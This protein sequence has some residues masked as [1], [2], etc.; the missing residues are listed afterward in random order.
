MKKIYIFLS[1]VLFSFAASAQCS[2]LYFSEYVE[3]SSNNKALE[4]YNASGSTIDLS[5]YAVIR[6]NNGGVT[7]PDTFNMN[8]MLASEGVYI[9]ANPSANAAILAL[10]DT[11]GSATF[12][13]GDDALA[14]TN[15]S[16]STIIDLF[17][18][19]GVDPGSAW[20]WVSGATNNSTLV[21]NFNVQSGVTAWDTLEWVSSVND[22][23]SNLG[24]HSSS[25]YPPTATEPTT[26]AA[27]P[28]A[29]QVDVISLFSN[30]YTNVTVDTWRTPWS[31]ATL[32]D[33][34]A[35]GNDIKRYT[36][37]DFVGIEAVGVNS[38]DASGMDYFTF[39][40]WTPN[41]TTYRIKVVDFGSDNAFGGGDDTEHQIEFASPAQAAWTNHKINM[42]DFTGL[43]NSANVSQFIFSALPTGGATLF[44]DNVYF[45][46][47]PTLVYNVS[48][49]A[50]VVALDA[51]FS[52]VN[53]DTLYEVTGIVYGID[54][55]GGATR[56]QFTLIDATD[57][58]GVF[59]E[60][61]LDYVVNEGD[62][63]TVKGPLGFFRG[64]TQIIADSITLVSTGNAI[65][66][67]TDV[68]SLSEATESDLVKFTKVW[69]VDNT[70]TEWTSGNTELTNGT[71][72][73]A[74][75]IDSDTKG[76]EGMAIEDTMDIIGLGGQFDFDAPYDEG[77]Q[78]FPR[79]SS[80]ITKWVALTSVKEFAIEARVYPNPAQ[81]SLTVI[82]SEKW[83]T[84]EV[85]NIVGSKVSE[86]ELN[87]NNLSVNDLVEGTYII[88][89]QAGDKAGVAR[90]VIN[91]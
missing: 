5:D 23:I 73:F 6:N 76:I 79:D 4:I 84:F 59:T 25:C 19:P 22:D 77:Y 90:F 20:T 12:Y 8:G 64:L 2:D 66:D 41:A 24:S 1:F 48:D 10:A 33:T 80:D 67:P 61:S 26:A 86:G 85:Y 62:E 15:I 39:D 57:G 14:L 34:T 74:V 9:I 89:L 28:T 31:S 75:R 65:N 50:D 70:I 81:N 35:D 69:L 56:T 17:G 16:T 13:N 78:L 30:V 11:T 36:G 29:D 58:V 18:V 45:S 68:T 43:T 40:A 72:T 42:S 51:D 44:I 52:P 83:N 21:R 38:I 82:G 32:K 49:I 87:N 63:V 47:E 3:G 37:L 91:R 54:Y 60:T 46:K 7:N 27:D 55:Q 88:K 71:D 53:L